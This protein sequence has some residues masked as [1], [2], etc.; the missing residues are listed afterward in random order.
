MKIADIVNGRD[1]ENNVMQEF[2]VY[3]KEKM[4]QVKSMDVQVSFAREKEVFGICFWCGNPVYRFQ[5]RKGK[6]METRFYC[7]EKCDWDLRTNDMVFATR[8]GV[9]LRMQKLKNLLR[10][11]L[12]C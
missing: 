12:S 8:L 5:A 3:I 2:E 10:K 1:N 9:A 7:S 11:N 4:N 6:V